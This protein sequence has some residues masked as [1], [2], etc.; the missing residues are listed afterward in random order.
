MDENARQAKLQ[1]LRERQNRWM[2]QRQAEIERQAVV[3]E[4]GYDTAT[5]SYTPEERPS[6]SQGR[7][8]TPSQDKRRESSGRRRP[9]ATS[10]ASGPRPEE[11]IDK[12]TEKI[13]ERLRE[14]LRGELKRETAD[15]FKVVE[16][17][18]KRFEGFLASEIESH[19]CPICYE[20]MLAPVY[21]PTMLFPCGHTFCASCLKA[22]TETHHKGKC[23]L[24]RQKIASKAVNHSLQEIIQNFANQRERLQD[25]GKVQGA[26]N[27]SSTATSSA[28]ISVYNPRTGS[29]LSSF[30]CVIGQQ[31]HLL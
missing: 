10:Q 8:Q 26:R 22:H 20:L 23:P 5:T 7:V 2:Q 24:C 6:S 14:E 3:A 25:G 19:T 21:S 11:V 12:L 16:K 1:Q 13:T 17:Q 30:F 27:V 28:A 29:C 4:L 18:G 15:A 31:T 9:A